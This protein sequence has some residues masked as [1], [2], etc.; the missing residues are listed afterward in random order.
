MGTARRASE[1]AARQYALQTRLTY[2]KAGAKGT[3]AKNIN[4]DRQ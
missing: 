4:G 2:P 3:V 1:G